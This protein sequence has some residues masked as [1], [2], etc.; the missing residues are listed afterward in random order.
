MAGEDGELISMQR[1][2]EQPAT[3]RIRRIYAASCIERILPGEFS[4]DP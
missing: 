3:L 4:R 1:L 2:R